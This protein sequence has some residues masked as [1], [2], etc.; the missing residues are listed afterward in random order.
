MAKVLVSESNLTNIANAIRAKNGSSNTYTPKQM[1]TAIQ[2]IQTGI[3]KYKV[4]CPTSTPNQTLTTT[5]SAIQTQSNGV[6]SVSRHKVKLDLTADSGY[7]AGSIVIDGVDLDTQSVSRN[8]SKD[9]VVT[10]TDATKLPYLLET[11]VRI[12]DQGDNIMTVHLKTDHWL[13]D[14]YNATTSM[15]ETNQTIV[16][17]GI[18]F[19]NQSTYPYIKVSAWN[20]SSQNGDYYCDTKFIIDDEFEVRGNL[21]LLRGSETNIG[22]NYDV[23]QHLQQKL[24]AGEDVIFKINYGYV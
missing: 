22:I 9:I 13:C 10:V 18:Q 3:P 23:I 19:N 14:V 24:Q 11:S 8:L 17:S 21:H 5:I 4:T 16:C 1:A 7:T 20:D 2:Q 6:Y 15:T 12:I